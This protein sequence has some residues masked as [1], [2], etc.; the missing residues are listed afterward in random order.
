MYAPV[1][2]EP[3]KLKMHILL[4]ALSDNDVEKLRSFNRRVVIVQF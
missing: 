2:Y 3:G 4:K 1:K